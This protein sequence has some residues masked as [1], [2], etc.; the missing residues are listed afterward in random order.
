MNSRRTFIKQLAAGTAFMQLP[1]LVSCRPKQEENK[2]VAEAASL[3][4]SLAQ[5]SIHRALEQGTLK[6]ID[7]VAIARQYDLN[8]V[9]YVASF[10]RDHATDEA[11]WNNLKK[12]ANDSGVKNLLIMVDEEGDLASSDKTERTKAVE[13]HYK[14]V[15]A[16]SL[17]GC[18]SIR[19][20]AFGQGSKSETQKAMIDAMSQLGEYA[21]KVNINVIIEN[22]GL[23][24]S[25]GKWVAEVLRQVD[26]PNCGTLPDFGNWCLTAQWGSTQ[27]ECVEQYDRYRGVAELLPYAKGVSAKS[28]AF[29]EQGEETRINYS[30]ML[31]VV[32]ESGFDGYIGIEFEGF[33]MSEPDGIRATKSLLEKSWQTIS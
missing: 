10:Y 31:K 15:N 20:N 2:P 26:R 27:I 22:H 4:L 25:D 8:A 18:H 21:E 9:E 14:W 19:V 13:N 23:Q 28:Y 3:K 6:A 24:S 11:Y 12:L 32:K 33:D 1:W 17:L 5:W 16:A 29:N 7:F 30:R